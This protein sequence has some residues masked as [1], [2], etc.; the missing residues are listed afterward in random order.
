MNGTMSLRRLS[1][2]A[3]HNWRARCRWHLRRHRYVKIIDK[4][5]F[6]SINT[7]H[8]GVLWQEPRGIGIA[9]VITGSHQGC[10][11]CGKEPAG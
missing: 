5:E 11:W 2:S 10:A 8:N 3:R 1:G 4:I 9:A 6:P 7:R